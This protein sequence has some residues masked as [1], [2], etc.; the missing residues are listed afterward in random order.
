MQM[1][2]RSM[3]FFENMIREATDRVEEPIFLTRMQ[4]DAEWN[5]AMCRNVSLYINLHCI[6]LTLS[7]LI[8][9]CPS[10]E[11]MYDQLLQA[12]LCLAMGY[13]V[14]T[15]IKEPRPSWRICPSYTLGMFWWALCFFSLLFFHLALQNDLDRTLPFQHPIFI[16]VLRELVLSKTRTRHAMVT[17]HPEHFQVEVDDVKYWLM[18]D[19]LISLIS[20]AVSHISEVLAMLMRSPD[21][22]CP[23][24]VCHSW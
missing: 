19:S 15:A 22:L 16:D 3:S 5:T 6:V 21:S 18:P 9:I 2:Q 7:S 17:E 20:S 8:P 12:G 14:L 11:A 4:E 23:W 13:R 1:A 24:P 10:W